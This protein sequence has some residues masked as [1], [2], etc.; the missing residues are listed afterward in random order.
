MAAR[1]RVSAFCLLALMAA[2][3]AAQELAWS[4]DPATQCRF[5]APRSLAGGPVFWTGA[6]PAG[7]AEG[8]GMLRRRDGARPGDA[9]YGEMRGGVPRIGVVDTGGGYRVGAFRDGEIGEG[10]LDW[11]QR[12]DAFDAAVR[13]AKAV[14][15]AYRAQ[16]NLASAR[17]YEGVARQLAMQND[18]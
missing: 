5:V 2:P 9:F 15:A 4:R 7:Q 16:G 1:H 11:Q 17:H 10:D 12:L 18:G 14:S 13:A 6:C 8:P 3:A